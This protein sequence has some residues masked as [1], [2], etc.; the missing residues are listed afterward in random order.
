MDLLPSTLMRAL[1]AA[2]PALAAEAP[3]T[4][5]ERAAGPPH[6]PVSESNI[7]TNRREGP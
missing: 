4:V 6:G 3:P 2:T 1:A 5:T 7:G